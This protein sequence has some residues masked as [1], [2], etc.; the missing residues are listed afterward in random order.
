M[1]GIDGM[2]VEHLEAGREYLAQM[3]PMMWSRETMSGIDVAG[4]GSVTG[5]VV[6]AWVYI[7]VVI[8]DAKN[9]VWSLEEF[10][11]DTV[12]RIN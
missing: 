1:P 4:E 5:R 9:N 11:A 12:P 8:R 3:Q 10:W 6:V 2:P 7:C